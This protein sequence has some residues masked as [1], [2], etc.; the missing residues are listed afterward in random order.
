VLE[1]GRMS[2][3][4][5][6]APGG[7]SFRSEALAARQTQWLGTVLLAPR[8]WDRLF[9][10]TAVLA[11]RAI[12][13]LLFPRRIHAQSQ[14]RRLAGAAGRDRARVRAPTRRGDRRVREGGS[15][16]QEGRAALLA[17]SAELQSATPGRDAGGNRAP[18][19]PSGARRSGRTQPAR[20]PARAAATRV[21]QSPGGAQV[22]AGAGRARYRGQKSRVGLSERN[23]AINREM[24]DQGYIS[25]Q[26][27]QLVE[28]DKLEQ[29]TRLGGAAAPAPLR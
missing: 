10:S 28:G 22:G 17:L 7:S 2:R 5:A 29:E 21:R 24:R 25:E 14:G 9:V 20:T 12:L 26:R 27:L 15:R 4:P 11:A 13:A 19:S 23:L 6:R 1:R 18:A 16:G 3:C 8:L